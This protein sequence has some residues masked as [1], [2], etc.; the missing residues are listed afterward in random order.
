MRHLTALVFFFSILFFFLWWRHFDIHPI[1]IISF[2]FH[3]G[4]LKQNVVS[5]IIVWVGGNYHDLCTCS[6][7]LKATIFN[8]VVELFLLIWLE[9]FCR[10]LKT[11]F[12]HAQLNCFLGDQFWTRNMMHCSS[13]FDARNTGHVLCFPPQFFFCLITLSVLSSYV[14][15]LNILDLWLHVALFFTSL[16][17][18]VLEIYLVYVNIS[19]FDCYETNYFIILVYLFS[20]VRLSNYCN[21]WCCFCYYTA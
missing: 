6:K 21:F 18:A 4:Q 13:F 2:A 17:P 15:N 8:A 3:H 5:I 19:M 14:S 16:G 20:Y 1:L 9:V 11:H 7:C 10:Y 12:S